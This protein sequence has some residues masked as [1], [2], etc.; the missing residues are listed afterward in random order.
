MLAKRMPGYPVFLAGIY[1]I[2]GIHPLAAL[3][4]QA[5]CGGVTVGIVCYLGR[6]VSAIVGIAAGF[7]T[8]LDPLSIGF[9]AAL[10][11]EIPFTLV[12]ILSLLLAVKIMEKPVNLWLWATFGAAWTVGIYLRAEALLCIFPLTAWMVLANVK[13]AEYFKKLMGP[14]IAILVVLVGLMPWWVRNYQLFHEDF[15][16]LTTLEG[17]SLYE[18]VYPGAN[19][20]PKQ[21]EIVL[22]A[23]MSAL[24]ESQRDLAWKQMA[25][26]QMRED[27][28]RMMRLAVIK[29][30]RTWSPGL[31]SEEYTSKTLNLILSIWYAPLYVLALAGIASLWSRRDSYKQN[32]LSRELLGVLL[33]TILYFTFMHAV[34]IG[35]V[36]YRVPLMPEV[37]ILAAIGLGWAL[38]RISRGQT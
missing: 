34:F 12:L 35:S 16:R 26:E 32:A 2:F 20:G 15:F 14:V 23:G 25:L 13:S 8:A 29:M 33:I 7:F 19:G 30:T 5:M 10:L 3:V 18:A 9:S 31:N 27:P 6:K 36:R 17:I 37:A 22:P 28:V 21:S 24:N 38:T 4:T 1:W 11:S